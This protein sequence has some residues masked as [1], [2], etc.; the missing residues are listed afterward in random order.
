MY[1]AYT[2]RT[3]FSFVERP[4]SHNRPML[5]KRA[6]MSSLCNPKV[7]FLNALHADSHAWKSVPGK[8]FSQEYF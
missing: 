8:N 5:L 6:G 7:H 4:I 2:T 3:G 1:S